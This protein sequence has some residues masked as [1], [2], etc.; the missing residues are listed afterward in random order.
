VVCVPKQSNKPRFSFYKGGIAIPI[1]IG[2]RKG[3]VFVYCTA[4]RVLDMGATTISISFSFSFSFS[5]F[6]FILVATPTCS[7]GL[8]T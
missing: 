2:N 5:F 4:R 3:V 7:H 8:N 1:K 6:S